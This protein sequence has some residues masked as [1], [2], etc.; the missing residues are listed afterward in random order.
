MSADIFRKVVLEPLS[1]PGQLDQALLLTSSG[2]RIALW[3]AVAVVVPILAS[4]MLISIS[5]MATGVGIVLKASGVPDV[6]A[7]HNGRLLMQVML[8]PWNRKRLD[9]G[10]N[11]RLMVR[12]SIS[13]PQHVLH[14]AKYV[15]CSSCF[16]GSAQPWWQRRPAQQVGPHQWRG[17]LDEGLERI[18][19]QRLRFWG[20]IFLIY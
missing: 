13:L 6:V 17:D 9:V 12:N 3:S 11:G 10:A 1:T 18:A 15:S 4:S 16:I 14:H 8:L 7:Q 5:F 19:H 20:G 2:N